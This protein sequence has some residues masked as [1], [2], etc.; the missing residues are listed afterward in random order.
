MKES[1]GE[2]VASHTAPE[3][4]GVNCSGTPFRSFALPAVEDTISS[5]LPSPERQ[6][7]RFFTSTAQPR[8]RILWANLRRLGSSVAVG[9]CADACANVPPATR[10][11]ERRG[12]TE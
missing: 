3:S 9:T 7:V 6:N 2:G 5:A 4:C 1:Y 10:F 12:E 11:D 8:N